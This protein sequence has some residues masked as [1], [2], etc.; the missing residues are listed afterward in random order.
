LKDSPAPTSPLRLRI[1]LGVNVT[2]YPAFLPVFLHF[3]RGHA[4]IF[5][6]MGVT[7]LPAPTEL[8]LWL[9]DLVWGVILIL[10]PAALLL[11]HF[12]GGD[13]ARQTKA[14]TIALVGLI[15]LAGFSVLALHMPLAT[16]HEKL[17]R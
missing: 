8:L 7:S 1:L 13:V 2:L 16:L 12:V 14:N 6:Q 9:P 4:V 11:L 3:R 15:L 5:T 17:S 10:I